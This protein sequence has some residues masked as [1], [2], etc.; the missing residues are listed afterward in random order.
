MLYSRKYD[1]EYIKTIDHIATTPG[2][3]HSAWFKDPAG[4]L[5]ALFQPE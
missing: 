2:I 5:I 4:N 1:T 3:G